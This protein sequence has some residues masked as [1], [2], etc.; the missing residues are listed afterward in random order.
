[1][2]NE[3]KKH[4][5]RHIFVIVQSLI[6]DGL[7]DVIQYCNS[8]GLRLTDEDLMEFFNMALKEV[9]KRDE[10]EDGKNDN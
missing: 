5:Q 7:K 10:K 3:N 8:E 9:R 2:I 6:N 1:M 4:V